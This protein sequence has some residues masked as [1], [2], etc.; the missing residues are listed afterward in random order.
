MLSPGRFLPPQHEANLQP[1]VAAF[2]SCDR[3]LG[4]SRGSQP[5]PSSPPP[6][7]GSSEAR[8]DPRRPC[9]RPRWSRR[10]NHGVYPRR[11][12]PIWGAPSPAPQLVVQ[13]IRAAHT[14]PGLP[15][16]NYYSLKVGLPEHMIA[17]A[18]Y[19]R[20]AGQWRFYLSGC[21]EH[22][23]PQHL[24]PL[25]TPCAGLSTRQPVIPAALC[26]G[27]AFGLEQR[28]ARGQGCCRWD[29]NCC[30]S[31]CTQPQVPAIIIGDGGASVHH[32]AAVWGLCLHL[33]LC[34]LG[35]GPGGRAVGLCLEFGAP[36]AVTGWLM[37]RNTCGMLQPPP[38]GVHA[39]RNPTR[40]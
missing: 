26:P 1:E 27:G 39:P 17:Q 20:A 38:N 37:E 7:S 21:G 11:M 8:G 2:L 40:V 25:S 10:I 14:Q 36:P 23:F 35:V 28:G 15:E 13:L 32:L 33:E 6:A 9:P 34:W 30:P 5:S 12:G 16:R 24:C 18:D 4:G 3:C 29:G 19:L 22:P 31:R